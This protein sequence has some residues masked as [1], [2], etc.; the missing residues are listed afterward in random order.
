MSPLAWI[1]FY[2]FSNEIRE[3]IE[4]ELEVRVERLGWKDS[5]IHGHVAGHLLVALARMTS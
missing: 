3:M 1:S 2:V 4:D 5:A